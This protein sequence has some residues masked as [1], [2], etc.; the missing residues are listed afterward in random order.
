M[1]VVVG[2]L[3]SFAFKDLFYLKIFME[4][5]GKEALQDVKIGFVAKQT[6]HCPIEPN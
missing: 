5:L 3:I 2:F 6:L 4:Q 1:V